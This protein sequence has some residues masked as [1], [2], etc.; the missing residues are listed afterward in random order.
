MAGFWELVN[1]SPWLLFLKWQVLLTLLW[2]PLLH[3][4]GGKPGNQQVLV[5]LC[6]KTVSSTLIKGGEKCG[7]SLWVDT[8]GW[9]TCWPGEGLAVFYIIRGEKKWLRANPGRIHLFTAEIPLC[10]LHY[11]CSLLSKLSPKGQSGKIL[12]IEFWDRMET[13]YIGSCAVVANPE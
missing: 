3:L 6:S 9:R 13:G 7:W 11:I 4:L 12:D 1:N 8:D 5:I 10:L 2:S